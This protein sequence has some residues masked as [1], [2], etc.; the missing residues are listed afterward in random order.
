MKVL[1]VVI[2]HL[3]E[4]ALGEGT[5]RPELLILRSATEEVLLSPL[6]R[7]DQSPEDVLGE[8]GEQVAS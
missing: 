5:H 7:R 6:K 2:L 8:V 1:Y 3:V 4:A